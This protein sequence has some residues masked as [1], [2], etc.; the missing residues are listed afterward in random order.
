MGMKRLSRKFIILLSLFVAF[1]LITLIFI[2][3]GA[4]TRVERVLFFPDEDG[5]QLHGELRRLPEREETVGNL[6]L[7]IKELLLGP[8]SIDLYRLFPEEVNIESLLVDEGILYLGFSENLITMAETVPMSLSG[9]I[10]GV[11]EAVVFNFPE[12]EEVK[13][14]IGGEPAGNR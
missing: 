2:T 5:Q 3:V 6:E 7:Y 8:V 10:E 9:I 11:E 13:T 14:V 1:F 12:I 4:D